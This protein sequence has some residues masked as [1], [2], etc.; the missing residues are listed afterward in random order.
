MKQGVTATFNFG[1]VLIKNGKSMPVDY[2]NFSLTAYKD[3][4]TA[5]GMVKKG[6][7][8][9]LVA[10][11]RGS[12]GSRGL[13]QREM[14]A[15]FKSFGCR[16]SYNLDGGGS[17]VL[18]YRGR[19]FKPSFGR[20]GTGLRRFSLFYRI[21]KKTEAEKKFLSFSEKSAKYNAAR[22]ALQKTVPAKPQ[23]RFGRC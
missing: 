18:V 23:L 19:V 5:V 15:I 12:G 13:N 11:G 7:Y 3:P 9:L 20:T 14:N 10:D 16:F 6:E 21:N 2:E 1:P 8:V 4:R 22:I 17:S